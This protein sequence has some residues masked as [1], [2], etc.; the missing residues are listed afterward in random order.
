MNHSP[1]CDPWPLGRGV[2]RAVSGT[3]H[4]TVQQGT[5]GI[6]RRDVARR[7]QNG[8]LR[9]TIIAEQPALGRVARR[10]PRSGP[11]AARRRAP[12]PRRPDRRG[13]APKGAGGMPRRHQIRAWKAAISPGELPNERRSRDARATQGTETSQYLEE[14]K[15]TETPLVAASER[16][17]AQTGRDTVRGCGAGVVEWIESGRSPLEN[18]T[19]AGDSPVGFGKVLLSGTQVGSGTGNPA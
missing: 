3:L 8:P 11:P 6:A 14:K 16:G 7:R 2:M 17:R 5:S 18:G 15:S 4:T 10:R 12:H 13:Q 1:A 9:I 19:K